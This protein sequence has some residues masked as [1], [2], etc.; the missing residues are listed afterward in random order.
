MK[1]TIP[2]FEWIKFEIFVIK[3][4]NLQFLI[5]NAIN[6]IHMIYINIKVLLIYEQKKKPYILYYFAL[7]VV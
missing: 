1:E 7:S 3:L 2:P 4:L 6:N 5:T